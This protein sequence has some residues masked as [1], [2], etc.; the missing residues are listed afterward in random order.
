MPRTAAILVIGNEVL[1]GKVHDR[2]SYFLCRE[3][4]A[5]GVQVARIVGIL[6]DIPTI[7]REARSL[8]ET[9]D[10]VFTSGG[11]G[12]THDDMTMEGIAHGF[13]VRAI[14]HPVLEAILRKHY[15]GEVSAARL[16]MALVPEGA[17]L[18]DAEGLFYPVPLFRNIYV[19]PGV[20]EILEQKFRG[21]RERF[22]DEPFHLKRLYLNA[23]ESAIADTL[24]AVVAAFP[25]TDIGSYPTWNFDEYKVLV[26]VESRD[27][28][29]L[30]RAFASLLE[31]IPAEWVV[32]TG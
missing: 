10:F 16:K 19:L 26:T 27:A 7:G 18:V 32:K 13:G 29:L 1:S 23:L 28:E 30:A 15:G 17:E 31:R 5:L 12:P 20:P 21:I 22:R 8:A 9:H 3:L 24:S 2:N 4:R 6:D 11:V 25:G 14:H